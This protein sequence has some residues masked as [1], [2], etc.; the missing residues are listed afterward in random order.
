[1][2]TM[3]ALAL[4]LPACT[5][6]APSGPAENAAPPCEF[7]RDPCSGDRCKVRQR[8]DRDGNIVDELV[9]YNGDLLYGAEMA[10]DGQ[11]LSFGTFEMNAGCWP[12]G[13]VAWYATPWD[14]I[15]CWNRDGVEYPCSE[16]PPSWLAAIREVNDRIGDVHEVTQ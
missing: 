6:A 14:P 11:I 12:G 8:A 13:A 9:T 1:M 16:I 15:K 2:R 5:G 4:I 3:L 10:P 7:E